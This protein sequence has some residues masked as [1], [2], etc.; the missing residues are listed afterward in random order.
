MYWAGMVRLVPV[1]IDDVCFYF[2]FS[3]QL[4]LVVC[5]IVQLVIS[6]FCFVTWSVSRT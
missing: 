4:A 3:T 1:V 5:E 2:Q 6:I